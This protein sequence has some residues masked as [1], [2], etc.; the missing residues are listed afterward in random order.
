MK[1]VIILIIYVVLNIFIEKNTVNFAKSMLG[2]GTLRPCAEKH[3]GSVSAN[4][5]YSFYDEKTNDMLKHN[6]DL[7]IIADESFSIRY[8]VYE[9]KQVRKDSMFEDMLSIYDRFK[10]VIAN[11]P[12]RRNKRRL[13]AV[14]SHLIENSIDSIMLKAEKSEFNI[15][16]DKP[17]RFKVLY[18]RDAALYSFV[19]YDKGDGVP[20]KILKLWESNGFKTTKDSFAMPVFGGI[21]E[22]MKWVFSYILDMQLQ[23]EIISV[24]LSEGKPVAYRFKQDPD[25][26]RI[27]AEINDLEIL[28]GSSVVVL[29]SNIKGMAYKMQQMWSYYEDDFNRQHFI[30]NSIL[31]SA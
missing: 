4:Y 2:N 24:Q 23:I 22:G 19:L 5:F 21:G 12:I 29:I 25:G 8:P 10:S 20:F 28:A 15:M 6:T 27:V 30:S 1:T 9:N 26:R 3:K 13:S 31:Q 14:F 18:D 17:I 11:I 16:P 7:E